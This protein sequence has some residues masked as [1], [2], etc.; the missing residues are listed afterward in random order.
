MP[1]VRTPIGC[2]VCGMT[3][4]LRFLGL[5]SVTGA[6]DPSA[7]PPKFVTYT[8][9][10]GG[11]GSLRVEEHPMPLHIARG[12]RDALAAILAQLEGE[13]AAAESGG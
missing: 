8:H 1:V 11:R 9:Q 12:L 2:P 13:I 6:Y 7:R 3:R 10:F 4:P 5:D